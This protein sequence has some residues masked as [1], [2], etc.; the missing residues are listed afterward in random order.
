MRQYRSVSGAVYIVQDEVHY[1][2]FL[3]KMN[4]WGRLKT[5]QA[6][7]LAPQGNSYWL[8]QG[9]HTGFSN[10]YVYWLLQCSTSAY[11]AENALIA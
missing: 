7:A 3:P 4:E 10:I 1:L 11:N 5:V 8:L 9:F 2:A 6:T